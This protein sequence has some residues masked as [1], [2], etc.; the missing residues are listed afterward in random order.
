MHGRKLRIFL[1]E[2]GRKKG[3]K[4][5][6]REW[7]YLRGMNCK[8]R[9]RYVSESGESV[10]RRPR[11]HTNPPPSSHMCSKVLCQKNDSMCGGDGRILGMFRSGDMLSGAPAR[12]AVLVDKW[13]GANVSATV[14]SE[15]IHLPD[16]HGIMMTSSVHLPISEQ[17]L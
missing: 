2:K 5:V 12:A 11:E 3:I 17:I 13:D 15:A 4:Y 8:Q 14:V 16:T 6:R 7:P 10:M 1:H 9:F